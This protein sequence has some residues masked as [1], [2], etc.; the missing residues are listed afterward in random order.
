MRLA[1]S[2]RINVRAVN[3][4]P[5]GGAAR[6]STRAANCV[7]SAGAA[8]HAAWLVCAV[9]VPGD[10]FACGCRGY[11]YH[12]WWLGLSA[13]F[14][15]LPAVSSRATLP[16]IPTCTMYLVMNLFQMKRSGYLSLNYYMKD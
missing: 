1:L 14:Q 10:Q 7:R 12:H 11:S 15:R 13:R 8:P 16:G 4:C 9:R 3:H 6:F 5:V 2:V